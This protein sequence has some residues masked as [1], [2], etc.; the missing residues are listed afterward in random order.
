[1]AALATH[2]SCAAGALPSYGASWKV[3]VTLEESLSG[4][5]IA[6]ERRRR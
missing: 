3:E 4:N 1:M 2:L 6:S 5:S